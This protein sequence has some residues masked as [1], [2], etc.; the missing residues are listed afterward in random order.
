MLSSTFWVELSGWAQ[1]LS[2][3]SFTA[4]S[5]TVDQHLLRQLLG[6]H[7]KTPLEFIYLETG[8]MPLK[9][10]ITR[11]KPASRPLSRLATFLFEFDT[12][13]NLIHFWFWYT[14]ELYT[15]FYYIHFWIGYTFGFGTLLSF[16]FFWK[17][18]IENM[19][20]LCTVQFD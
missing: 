9:Y 5:F 20:F 6:A 4:R 8:C 2:T 17:H 10:I 12:L 1:W 13:L 15:P 18:G 16:I 7:A 11:K 19:I 3:H 14:F